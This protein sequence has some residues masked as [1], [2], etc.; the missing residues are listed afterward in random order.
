MRTPTVWLAA[1]M[2]AVAGI[3]VRMLG[4]DGGL[5][6]LL[7]S[8]MVALPLGLAVNLTVRRR[9][10]A[11]GESSPDSVEFQSAHRARSQAYGDTV[12][13]GALLVLALAVLDGPRGAML[14]LAFLTLAVAA[15]WI[16]YRLALKDLRG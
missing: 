12:I 3:A 10:D 11:A 14:G 7:G 1:A 2:V 8:L 4:G 9:R 5:P 13:L 15:F 16:R 6:T